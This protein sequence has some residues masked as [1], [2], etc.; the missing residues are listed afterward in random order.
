MNWKYYNPKFEYEEKFDDSA[1]PW[2]GH[3]YFAYDLVAN[4]K[5]KVIVE[6]G[7]H[8]GTSLWSFSQAVKDQKIE[9]ELNAVDTWQGE[10]HAGF[11]GEEVFETVNQIK[12]KYYKNLKINLIRKTFDE[13]LTDFKDNSIDI[14]HID[15]LHTY[16]SVKCDFENW[17]PKLKQDGIIIFH[18]IKVQEN[19]FGVYK[20]W[21]ELKE[22]YVTIEFF[23][24]YGLGVLF[25]DKT[26]GNEIK[27]KEKEWQMHYSYI[28]E[29]IKSQSINNKNQAVLI[30]QQ[31]IQIKVQE[32]DSTKSQLDTTKSQLD[33]T[34]S[35]LDTT[36][37]QLDTTKSQL[38]TTK[39]QLDTT[40]S[41]LDL[42][43][44]E[45]TA[46][47]AC[48]GWRI[49]VLL[50]KVLEVILPKGSLRRK[51]IV[52]SFRF[53]KKIILK[54]KRSTFY[55]G[56]LIKRV[57]F[58]LKRDG[59]FVFVKKV[60][61]YLFCKK[62]S[63]SIPIIES[64]YKPMFLGDL[65]EEQITV[66]VHLYYTGMWPDIIEKLK[67]IP[68][69]YTLIISLTEGHY[70]QLIIKKIKKFKP[71]T[72]ILIFENKG[73][74]IL[75]F[76][77]SMKYIPQTTKYLLKIH[78]KKSLHSPEIGDK[79][80]TNLMDH[81]L[82][83]QK[84][85]DLILHNL[86]YTDIGMIGGSDLF[87]IFRIFTG[88]E[89]PEL[90]IKYIYNY[91]NEEHSSYKWISGTMFWVRYDIISKLA[92]ETF[93]SLVEKKQPSGYVQ[94]GTIVHGIER[95]FGKLVYDTGKTLSLIPKEEYSNNFITFNGT[96][97]FVNSREEHIVVV[98]H[99]A[100][101]TGAPILALNIAKTLNNDFKKKVITIL[102]RGGPLE[103]EFKKYGNVINLSQS[104]LR[105]ESER[106][107]E[108]IDHLF[109]DLA[110]AGINKCICNTVLSGTLMLFLSKHGYSCINL[111]HELSETI[112]QENYIEA[113]EQLL[114]YST[115]LVFSSNFVKNDFEKNFKKFKEKI[116]IRPQGI[117][118]K[119]IYV[120]KKD[121]AGKMLRKK[122][123][124]KSS[125]KIILG[126]GSA[127]LKKGVD[128]FFEIANQI[129]NTNRELQCYFVWLGEWDVVLKDK[130]T[131]IAKEKGFYDKMILI[132]FE[133][134]PSLFFAG[135]DVFLLPSRQDPFPSVV[136]NA[137]DCGTP[138]IAFDKAG[139]SPEILANQQGIVVSYLDFKSMGREILHLLKNRKFYETISEN[140]KKAVREK[141]VFENYVKFLLDQLQDNNKKATLQIGSIN[142]KVSD[143]WGSVENTS[144]RYGKGF[145]W[146][147]SPMVMERIN[148]KI[149]GDKNIDWVSYVI[150]K[151]LN[152]MGTYA[153]LSLGCG[154]GNLERHLQGRKIFKILDAVDVSEGAVLEAK[155]L[156][157]EQDFKINYCVDDINNIKLEQNKYKVVFFNSSLH[158]IVN[159]EHVLD[160]IEKTLTD[161][162]ILII[163]EYVGP[164]QFQFSEIQTAIINKA[165]DDLPQVY[166][167]SI[168][169]PS[170]I[171]QHHI[172][173]SKEYMNMMDPSEAIRSNEIT[174]VLENKFNV[175]ERK[176]YGGTLL[177]FLL[178]DIIG[179]FNPNDP[180]DVSVLKSIFDL[181]DSVIDSGVLSSDFTL[182]VLKKK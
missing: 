17:L 140:A 58:I 35:Q 28:H 141:F 39:S 59:I 84:T 147:E 108:A 41:Q 95:Y 173:P 34:K 8:Y 19:D 66:V 7:T 149:S 54:I 26:F 92:D 127:V 80:F 104:S 11:Y 47:Y 31:G 145:H 175:I 117:Y 118:L 139:G 124:L 33:T 52:F 172:P 3:R 36:K 94:A 15:G 131:K 144:T 21:E 159:I 123:G 93:I 125:A 73:M 97:Y 77:K 62:V 61:K 69:K 71:N 129:S 154:A 83:D 178:Q 105:I 2:V 16:K 114:S 165:I 100:S 176:D 116:Y 38:D 134:N 43:V 45:L 53:C 153:S 64:Y 151:Y 120:N 126:C 98:S 91:F 1:W 160:E 18:D 109:A 162:G 50:R 148:E 107:K 133:D 121:E 103:E 56:R 55:F 112:K 29:A 169:D 49:I 32:L 164:S 111:V 6:L 24:A 22:K 166:R 157:E 4:I 37:S 96:R 150:N 179:N 89:M 174:G 161:D 67:N 72:K 122:L 60:F 87:D 74:D 63:L 182:M 65:G 12:D 27:S 99:E 40:K 76:L 57:L 156:A 170:K 167:K 102:L 78:T 143:F 86:E 10:K 113:T 9:T 158:H 90:E 181:E 46:I 128:F 137:M 101:K 132:D 146:V 168:S 68:Y 30:K 25:L 48:R 51:V 23:Q 142:K 42:R 115:K 130:L 85:V 75:P 106:D 81:V 152:N 136:L 88:D 44:S 177:Q 180:N 20:L 138:V 82:L 135:S 5:P 79:W 155:K 171:K 13:A 163:N 119:N 70:D 110:T 14:L